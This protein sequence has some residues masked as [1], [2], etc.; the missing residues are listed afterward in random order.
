MVFWSN[1]QINYSLCF[2]TWN[3]KKIGKKIKVKRKGWITFFTSW[4]SDKSHVFL[5]SA[6]G[7]RT[8]R[9]ST[10]AVTVACVGPTHIRESTWVMKKGQCLRGRAWTLSWGMEWVWDPEPRFMAKLASRNEANADNG[11]LLLGFLGQ[12]F[13]R[14]AQILSFPDR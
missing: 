5:M 9:C 3:M 14:V 2:N 1:Q 11:N 10:C 13:E 4:G 8:V 12:I 7:N 6:T